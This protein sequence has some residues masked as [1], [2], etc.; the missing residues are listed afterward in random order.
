MVSLIIPFYNS[1]NT[2]IET[3][4]SIKHQ[5]IVPNEIIL[6]NDCSSDNT[7]KIIKDFQKKNPDINIKIETNS[8]RLGPGLS[9]NRG[10]SASKYKYIFFLDSDVILKKNSIEQ[11][12]FYIKKYDSVIG[13]YT[14]EYNKK[15]ILSFVK[16][17]YYFE[18]NNVNYPVKTS[19]FHAAICGIKKS[20]FIDVGGYDKFFSYKIDFE[21]E[22]LGHRINQKYKQYLC[23]TIQGD[24]LWPSNLKIFKTMVQRPSYFIEYYLSK[25]GKN[26][27]KEGVVLTKYEAFKIF[28]SLAFIFLNIL[29]ISISNLFIIPMLISFFLIIKFNYSYFNLCKKDGHHIIKNFFLLI[30]FHNIIG[31]GIYFGIIKYLTKTGKIT[32]FFKSKL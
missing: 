6:V 16:A 2:I 15:S 11:F 10:C 18:M 29:I 19:I 4:Y 9:R 30:L 5:T 25:S 22:E 12:L 13:I 1:Q 23:P 31:L 26:Q 27:K 7:I 24:H 3:L 17:Y 8:K 20:V 21:N 28:L 14:R 32:N